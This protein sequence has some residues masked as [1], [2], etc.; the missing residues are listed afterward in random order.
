MAGE[1]NFTRIPP[2][3]TGDRVYMVHTMYIPYDGADA[4]YVWEVGDRYYINGNGGNSITVHVH[5][6]F[7]DTGATSGVLSVHIVGQDRFNNLTPINDQDIRSDS[8]TG[9]IRAQVN[10]TINVTNAFHDVYVPTTNIMGYDNPEYG[11]DIDIKGSANV[12]FQE[13]QPQLDAWGKLRTS[14]A[15]Q[16]GDYVFSSEDILDNNFSRVAT[17]GGPN[18]TFGEETSFVRYDLTKRCVDVGVTNGSDLATATS[19]T[20][21]PYIA[22]SSHLFMGTCLFSGAGTVNNPVANGASRR[23]GIFDAKNG[24]MFHVGPDGVLYLEQR[25]SNGLDYASGKYD[26]LLA[27]SDASTASTLGIETFNGDRV[28]GSGGATN[29]SGMTLDLGKD[30]QYWIDLQWHGAGRVRFGT[31]HNGARVVIHEYY[32]DNRYTLPMNQ[33]ISLPCCTAVYGYPQSEIDASNGTQVENN[34]NWSATSAVGISATETFIREFSQAMWTET[35]VN[36]QQLGLPR[37]YSTAH[38][39]VDGSTFNYL[40]SLG[41]QPLA[42]DGVNTNHSLIVP[43]KITNISYD[44]NVDS[45]GLPR[46]AIV[47]WRAS[48]NTVMH[49]RNWTDIPNSTL[50]VASDGGINYEI[51]DNN[52]SAETRI[53]EDMSIGRSTKE[54]SDTF[55]N[56]QNGAWKQASD[57]GGTFEEQLAT[58]TNSSTGTISG[59]SGDAGRFDI[60]TASGTRDLILGSS[61]SGTGIPAG[62]HVHTID[63]DNDTF[64][65]RPNVLTG[66][67]SGTLNYINPIEV[68][69]EADRWTLTEPYTKTFGANPGG[70]K[71]KLRNNDGTTITAG[72]EGMTTDATDDFVYLFITG[73]N[74]G[75]LYNDASWTDPTQTL[76]GSYTGTDAELYGFRGADF[77]VDFFAHEQVP[78]LQDPRSMFVIEWKEIRQE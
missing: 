72:I 15:T 29:P 21:H 49:N 20:Y 11:L 65:I 6:V 41:I 4:N 64:T 61:I 36:L 55:I 34:F 42:R 46:E 30:N 7:K 22:G 73:R 5:G 62:S 63:S 10:G 9:T 70:G 24:F 35:D 50:R 2:E 48:T 13:G 14:G 71:Y 56:V 3:S 78:A 60:R 26:K 32:H 37:T 31:F 67:V 74:K 28:D 39:Q 18:A 43:T 76:T 25:N 17:Q 51:D 12:R 57:D 54:L 33:T 59:D 38:P 77:I 1:R 44:A 16:L 58:I 53:F 45:V 40:F 23:F 69:A 8:F 52:Q 68:T 27:C 66:S 19:K 75:V 47:H